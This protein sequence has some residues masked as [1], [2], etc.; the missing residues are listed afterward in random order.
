MLI[1]LGFT[2]L[3]SAAVPTGSRSRVGHMNACGSHEA[4]TDT[5]ADNLALLDKVHCNDARLVKKSPPFDWQHKE[6]IN[7]HTRAAPNQLKLSMLLW[8]WT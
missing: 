4:R 7:G 8:K 6:L 3:P 1:L 5:V 2:V